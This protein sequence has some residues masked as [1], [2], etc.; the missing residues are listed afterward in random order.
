MI[1]IGDASGCGDRPVG[2][3]RRAGRETGCPTSTATP[4][5]SVPAQL[6]RTHPNAGLPSEHNS[7]RP[8]SSRSRA[9]GADRWSTTAGSAWP[10]WSPETPAR[11]RSPVAAVPS[12]RRNSPTARQAG[13]RSSGPPHSRPRGRVRSR[14]DPHRTGAPSNGLLLR[15]AS[16][17]SGS[18]RRRN[19]R[20]RR[21]AEPSHRPGS[22]G[23]RSRIPN[24]GN[25][26]R[27][28]APPSKPRR[29]SSTARPG[30][31]SRPASSPPGHSKLGRSRSGPRSNN[32]PDRSE[33]RSHGL[34]SPRSSLRNNPRGSRP[35]RDRRH[36]SG[37][38][39]RT[40]HLPTSGRALPR[41]RV[42]ALR[43]HR[44][45]D[46]RASHPRSSAP[47]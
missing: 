20:P 26:H 31:S 4:Q 12:R 35:H 33:R 16:L 13:R 29:R 46:A 8:S 44:T 43:H 45:A 17:L 47:R 19:V 39:V 5:A 22:N 18:K 2:S 37:H 27:S 25:G 40:G 38:R 1:G 7:D 11:I 6:A 28:N 42:T 15:S 9:S 24:A 23:P 3:Q 21:S 36:S 34:P 14:S 41:G 30:S 32:H 10:T